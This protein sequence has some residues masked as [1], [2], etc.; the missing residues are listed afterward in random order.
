M[1]KVIWT[2]SQKLI[3]IL[4]ITANPRNIEANL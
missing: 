2:P 3:R 1:I 4:R